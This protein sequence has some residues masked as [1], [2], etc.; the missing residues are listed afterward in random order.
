MLI[1][2]KTAA[3]DADKLLKSN[4]QPA[5]VAWAPVKVVLSPGINNLKLI[6][7]IHHSWGVYRR[8]QHV[9][10]AHKIRP[11]NQVLP[12]TVRARLQPKGQEFLGPNSKTARSAGQ[13]SQ[14]GI[15]NCI[16]TPL[17]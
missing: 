5:A 16:H 4:K 12:V 9:K 2:I 13:K 8:T 3:A 7:S 17:K 1:A 11:K 15:R 6:S 14:N 10:N